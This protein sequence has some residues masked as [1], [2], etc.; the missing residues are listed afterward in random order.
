MSAVDARTVTVK[1]AVTRLIR[2]LKKDRPLF[3]WGPPGVGKSEM[4]QH[5]VDSGELGKA[6]LIDIRASLLDPTDVRGFPAPD[7]ANNR[8]VWLPPVDFPTEEEAA[9]YDTIVMLFDE[10]NSGAQSVQAALY[11]LIL[12]KKVGQYELPKNVKIVAAGNRESDKGVTSR[13]PSSA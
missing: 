11:Q 8:M 2:A 3:L 13:M 10:L 5:V 12:N 6:K 1:Q 4:C 7:L 9:K